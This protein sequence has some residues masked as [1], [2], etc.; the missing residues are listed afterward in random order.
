MMKLYKPKL[1]SRLN[2][3]A[4]E[5]AVE[6]P[7][8]EGW[9]FDPRKDISDEDWGLIVQEM[10]DLTEAVDYRHFLSTAKAT[11]IMRPDIRSSFA[12][13]DVL[14]SNCRD[15][16]DNERRRQT[17][18]TGWVASS[19]CVVF[20]ERVPELGFSNEDFDTV[21]HYL[22]QEASKGLGYLVDELLR[23]KIIFPERWTEHPLAKDLYSKMYAYLTN[24]GVFTKERLFF[25]RDAALLFPEKKPE[26]MK[27]CD[28]YSEAL[29][30]LEVERRKVME[31]LEPDDDDEDWT[32]TLPIW[33]TFKAI[34]LSLSVLSADEVR[35]NGGEIELISNKVLEETPELPARNLAQ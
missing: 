8:C 4:V 15:V 28:F 17:I 32:P 27:A 5:V 25:A 6:H 2:P 1:E 21:S 12:M 19:M 33:S 13:D 7:K 24:E 10:N 11:L 29:E 14:F 30:A 22:T 3:R 18:S 16:L 23:M 26:I 35:I 31:L 9:N 20:S 34:A